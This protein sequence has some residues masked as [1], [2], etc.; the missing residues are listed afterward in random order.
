[1]KTNLPISLAAG[2]PTIIPG[3]LRTSIRRHNLL[4][5]RG[6]LSVL[7]VYRVI[8]IPGKVKLS[9][10]TDPF[11]GLSDTLQDYEIRVASGELFGFNK[12]RL[13]PIKLLLLGTAGP[14]HPRSMLGV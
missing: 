3:E 7:A 1:L 8:N 12:L 4:D 14:N 2:L 9:T 5:C 6:V 10:I 13:Q 11:K